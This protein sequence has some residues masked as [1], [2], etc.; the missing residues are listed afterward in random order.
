MWPVWVFLLF[1]APLW[2]LF[3]SI[4]CFTQNY[5]AAKKTGLP[6]VSSPV[7][8]RSLPWLALS[9][10]LG[11]LLLKAPFGLGSWVR[12]NR[13]MWVLEEKARMFQE[14]GKVFVVVNP[15]KL[16]VG[17]ISAVKC[18]M[19]LADSEQI[20]SVDLDVIR[21]V[22]LRKKH[23]ERDLEGCKQMPELLKPSVSSAFGADWQRHRRI[24]APPFN[25]SNMK[26]VWQESLTQA[27]G[28]TQWWIS[29]RLPPC[30]PRSSDESRLNTN[31]SNYFVSSMGLMALGALVQTQ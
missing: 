20:Y 8:S 4:V 23:F 27:S 21:Q 5:I 2:Q 30:Y 13:Y 15:R 25:E 22:Y 7:Y 9:P 19:V 1:A 29:V 24:T 17:Y 12:Y 31:Q 28:L 6:I 10:L 16:Q 11:P 3:S 14:K 18:E 26:I